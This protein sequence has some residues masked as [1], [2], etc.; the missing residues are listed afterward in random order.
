MAGGIGVTPLIAMAHRLHAIGCDFVLH[1]S[2]RSR[3]GCGFAPVIATAPWADRAHLHV[4]AEGARADLA[5]LIP[6]YGN[7]FRLYTC[8]GE[9]YMDAVQ[10]A[11][12]GR[13]WPEDALSRE[14]FTVPKPP[15][16]VNHPF[17]LELARSG[18]RVA[19][20]ADR[21]AT[22][23]LAEAGIAVT[24][25]CSDGICGVCATPHLGSATEHRDYVLS[26][27]ERER[28]VALCCSR[29]AEPGS[30]LRLEL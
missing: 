10:T 26:R 6:P 9:R 8:G 13:R 2:V 22:E 16:W 17:T 23:A 12:A 18:R 7:G 4:S 1:Y 25:K 20:P 11:A 27:A 5:A 28:K 24:S 3:E 29:A 14:F 30:V 19:V 21:S 15:D